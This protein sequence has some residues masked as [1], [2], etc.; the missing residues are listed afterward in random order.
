MPALPMISNAMTFCCWVYSPADAGSTAHGNAF[1]TQRDRGN[2]GGYGIANSLK[3]AAYWPGVDPLYN[4]FGYQWGGFDLN[5]T[6]AY[7]GYQ[8]T[9]SGIYLS[10]S[11]WTF[12]ALVLETNQA[13]IYSGTNGGPLTVATV[14]LPSTL[15]SA[16]DSA[17]PG[18]V[19]SNS[20][21][22]AL[23]RH[24]WPWADDGESNAV[25]NANVAMSD[26]AIF[27]T[28]LSPLSV[29]NLYGAAVGQ[30]ITY[31]NTAGNL[32][33]SWPLGTLQ[34]STNVL[35]TY[36]NVVGATSPYTT[37]KTEKQRY[38]RAR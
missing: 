4:Q 38:Y 19:Y 8:W 10:H 24:A 28:P 18:T 29:S 16:V 5:P 33:L 6:A 26:V 13:R 21:P 37:S 3:F 25:A 9:N 12:V 36:T 17:F 20:S 7:L 2:A 30:L 34:A 32:V 15:P 22:L 11:N 1:I 35:G 23:G 27:Y 31:T 14:A